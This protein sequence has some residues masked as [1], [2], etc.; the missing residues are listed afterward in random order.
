MKLHSPPLNLEIFRVVGATVE[1][2]QR[3]WAWGECTVT[4]HCGGKEISLR[5]LPVI[6]EVLGISRE[7]GPEAGSKQVGDQKSESEVY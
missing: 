1:A 6:V 2:G 7:K 3:G 5:T 4:K